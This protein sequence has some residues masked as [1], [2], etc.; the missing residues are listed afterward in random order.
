[1][2]PVGQGGGGPFTVLS[3]KSPGPVPIGQPVYNGHTGN[4]L[5]FDFNPFH[6]YIIASGSE[7]ASIKVGQFRNITL[8]SFRF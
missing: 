5:D 2:L 3:Y 8:S 4:V 7:D 6:D 1:M